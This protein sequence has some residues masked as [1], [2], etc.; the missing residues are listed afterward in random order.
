MSQVKLLYSSENGDRWFLVRE[1]EPARVF[2]RHEPNPPSGG[3]ISNIDIG[4][5]LIRGGTGPEKRALLQLIGT[6]VED[7]AVAHV[8]EP[9]MPIAFI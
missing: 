5:F 4:D 9:S 2:V 7:R 8:D 6:L 1:T 3:R